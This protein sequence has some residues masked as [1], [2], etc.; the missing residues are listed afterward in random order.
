M[1]RGGVISSIVDNAGNTTNAGTV[2]AGYQNFLICIEMLLAAVA[3]RYAF[4]YQVG[5]MLIEFKSNQLT[6]FAL[7]ICPKLCDW[8]SRSLRYDAINLQ[9]LKGKSTEALNIQF[10]QIYFLLQETMNP[11]DIMTDAI[12]NFHPQY[13]QYTQYSSGELSRRFNSFVCFPKIFRLVGWS[14]LHAI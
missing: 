3:L 14:Y 6:L 4:P 1:E 8:H 2:S 13:Q 9:Q 10:M 5:W 7:G 11:K 12:H